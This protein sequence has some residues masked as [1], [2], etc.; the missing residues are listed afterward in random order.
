MYRKKAKNSTKIPFCIYPHVNIYNI[1]QLKWKDS[2]YYSEQN[3]PP[4][5]AFSHLVTPE[6]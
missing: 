1:L 5:V 3:H 2:Y 4:F 6:A